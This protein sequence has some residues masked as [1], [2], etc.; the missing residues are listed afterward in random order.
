[1]LFN[2]SAEMVDVRHYSN[3]SAVESG[4]GKSNLL[5]ARDLLANSRTNQPNKNQLSSDFSESNNE[6]PL[7]ND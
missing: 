4:Q 1:M 2:K 3:Q 6:Q 5:R 7:N